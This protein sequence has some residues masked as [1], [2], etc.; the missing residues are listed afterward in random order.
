MPVLPDLGAAALYAAVVFL[1]TLGLLVVFVETIPGRRAVV[2]VAGT[3][4]AAAAFAFASEVG[5][6]LLTVAMG[7]AV[8][9]SQAFEWLTTR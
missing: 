6:A 1:V 9:A 2:V 7:A 4:V 8:A 5:L 3:I